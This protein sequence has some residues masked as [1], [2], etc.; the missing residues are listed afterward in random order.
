MGMR[1]TLIVN[2]SSHGRVNIVAPAAAAENAVVASAFG[3]KMFF[4]ALG[5]A[6]AH[7]EGR[8]GLP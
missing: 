2:E 6:A 8:M 3:F 1:L 5:H 7:V 4:L